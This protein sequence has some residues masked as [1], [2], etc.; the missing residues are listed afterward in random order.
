MG[1][2]S[3][4]ALTSLWSGR[5]YRRGLRGG[6]G[7]AR[8]FPPAVERVGRPAAQLGVV[9]QASSQGSRNVL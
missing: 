6:L 2:G 1:E 3:F 5:G 9:R 7:L 8:R 4:M